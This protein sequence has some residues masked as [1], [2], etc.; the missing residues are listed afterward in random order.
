MPLPICERAAQARAQTDQHVAA[1]IRGDPRARLHVA[2]AHHRAGFHRR[3]HLVAGAVEEARVDERNALRRFG[4]TGEQV[5]AGAALLV[6]DAHLD[7]VARQLEQVFDAREQL[8]RERDFG[9]AVHLRLDDVDRAGARVQLVLAV[10]QRAQRG[11]HRV[12]N[13]FRNFVAVLRQ[14]RRI[15]HQMAD[16]ADEQQ[17]AAMQHD[18]RGAVG[19]DVHA[20]FVQTAR[21][22]LAVLRDLFGQIAL[23]QAEPVAIQLHL[24][25]R[26]DGRDRVFAI[27][28]RA[29]R[30]FDHH[31][32]DMRRIGLADRVVRVDLDL[33]VQAVVL[34]QHRRRRALVALIADELRGL[35]QLARAV[36]QRDDQLAAFDAVARR[37]GVRAVRERRGLVEKLARI[38]D[39]RGAA[40]R[41][42][43]L[44]A[45]PRRSV[46]GIASVPYSAS[47][48]LPQRAFAAFSA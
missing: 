14:D 3:V 43:G 2:L 21:E 17:R 45:F 1:L 42:E 36:L 10:V 39:H 44:A 32:F 9:R 25:V 48:R 40:H 29:H 12:E 41:V 24:V 13:A 23:H 38:R 31:V 30:R 7:R 35:L 28:D 18:G 26:I 46:S 34:E 20:I 5:H 16:V 11:D 6:H 37:V 8:A 47:Y 19:G 27:D 33:D 22:G 15:G 4:D